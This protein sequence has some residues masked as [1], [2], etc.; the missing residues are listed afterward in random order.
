M[1]K[2]TDGKNVHLCPFFLTLIDFELF[3][4]IQ[5]SLDVPNLLQLTYYTNWMLQLR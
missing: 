4:T 3:F 1:L 2:T 5:S